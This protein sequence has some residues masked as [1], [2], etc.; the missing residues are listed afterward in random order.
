MPSSRRDPPLGQFLK[1][2]HERIGVLLASVMRGIDDDDQQAALAAWRPFEAGLRA[3]FAAE[4]THL[5]PELETTDRFEAAQ[6]HSDHGGIRHLLMNL[7][8]CLELHTARKD[9][10]DELAALL[11]HHAAREE[12]LLY[13]W[14]ERHAPHDVGVAIRNQLSSV[15]AEATAVVQEHPL[16]S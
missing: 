13:R 1:H 7:G 4:E 6:L 9:A 8:M 11:E 10:F 15:L 12:A 14:A 2:D 16:L 3:H 5:F